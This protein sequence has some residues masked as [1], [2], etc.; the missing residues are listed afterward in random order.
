MCAHTDEGAMGLV[1]NQPIP[2]V[3]LADILRSVDID[4]GNESY[5]PVYIGG[6]IEVETSFFIYSSEYKTKHF[7]NVSDSVC[8]SREPEMLY[9]I[10][11]GRG[12]K[13]YIFVMGY[14]GWAPGQLENEL[15]VNGWLTI[16]GDDHLLFDVRDELKWKEAAKAY[17]IDIKLYGDVIGNA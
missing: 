14:A 17:G 7:I 1:V 6:P 2:H 12:P 11:K 13:K 9:D 10:A 4:I 3:C 16:P 15:K 5:P 8:L